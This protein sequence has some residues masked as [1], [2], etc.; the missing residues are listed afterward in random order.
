MKSTTEVDVILDSESSSCIVDNLKDTN[1]E[2]K[3]EIPI[4]PSIYFGGCAFGSIFCK[5][6]TDFSITI[7]YLRF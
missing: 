7:I 1:F 3:A 2:N 5:F 4:P 6:L